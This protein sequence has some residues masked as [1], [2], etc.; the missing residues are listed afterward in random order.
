[1]RPI[2]ERTENGRGMWVKGKRLRA[3]DTIAAVSLSWGGPGAIPHRYEAGKRQLMD[4]F[5][6]HV[7]ETAHALR[8]PQW[9]RR[10]PEAR[11]ADL[12]DAFMNP[13][14]S[15]IISTIGGEESIR[16]L[17]FIDATII[18]DNPKVFI[19][20]SDTTVTHLACHAAGLVTFYGPSIMTGFAE[21][22]GIFPYT[23]EAV[24]RTI[25]SADSGAS[26]VD[27]SGKSIAP[28]QARA[29]VPVALSEW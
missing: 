11:A 25:F 4:T 5:G 14:V 22:T 21:N 26:R 29:V 19:G 23:A 1:M 10:N 8:D 24:R 18:R 7:I 17:P 28:P 27:R 6:L 16:I 9:L 2:A 13:K 3:G 15:G 20:Y 12:M